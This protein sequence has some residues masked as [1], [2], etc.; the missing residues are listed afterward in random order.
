MT[1]SRKPLIFIGVAVVLVAVVAGY[2]IS[3]SGGN[4]EEALRQQVQ[5][6]WDARVSGDWGTVYDLTTRAFKENMSKANFVGKSN[7]I[8]KDFTVKDVRVLESG[9]EGESF[10][11]YKMSHMG[12]DFDTKSK[13]K[14]VWE[15]GAWHME[16]PATFSPFKTK[17][18]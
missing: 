11:E 6:E 18:G 2:L 16:L 15:D 3:V 1:K 17:T 8:I 4:T 14:W 9:K 5:K 10:V 7:I 13:R 12:F